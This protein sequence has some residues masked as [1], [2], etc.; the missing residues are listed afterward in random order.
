[1]KCM[2]YWE[3]YIIILFLGSMKSVTR[4]R[5]SSPVSECLESE[6]TPLLQNHNN[7]TVANDTAINDDPVNES[8]S[9][10]YTYMCT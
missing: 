7:N 4:L 6:S 10:W 5:P 2:H 8:T 1:M 9:E 3:V